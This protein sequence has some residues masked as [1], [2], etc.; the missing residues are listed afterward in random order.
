MLVIKFIE[1]NT[2]KG[3]TIFRKNKKQIIRKKEGF[4]CC[5]EVFNVVELTEASLTSNE[6]KLLLNRYTGAVIFPKKFEDDAS[7]QRYMFDPSLYYSRAYLSALTVY[8]KS[9]GDN[10]ICVYIDNFRFCREWVELANACRSILIVGSPNAELKRFC[11]FC[12]VD[13]GLSPQIND[14]SLLTDAFVRVNLNNINI[15]QASIKI[16]KAQKELELYPN[17]RY[18]VH[19]ENVKKL[20]NMG[21]S[22][23]VACAAC[24]VVPF[25]KIYL[26]NEE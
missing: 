26:S 7:L 16:S 1:N 22:T 11:E 19:N 12:K 10:R 21:I 6:V 18:F 3:F 14:T 15:S 4:I 9:S 25:K 5:N 17:A 2:G 23:G 8:L 20:I 13:L 24:Q